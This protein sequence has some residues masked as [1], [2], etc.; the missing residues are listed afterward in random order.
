MFQRRSE[1]QPDRPTYSYMITPRPSG[2]GGGWCLHL[3]KDGDEIKTSAFTLPL[4]HHLEIIRWWNGLN[5][6]DHA[7]W[8]RWADSMIP[9]EV[10]RAYFT[11]DTYEKALRE[12][13]AWI[14]S[15]LEQS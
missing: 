1:N 14:A 7:Y 5:E 3:L 15:Q 13:E 8:M 11:A 2:L 10:Y 9:A 6:E 4:G 12:A